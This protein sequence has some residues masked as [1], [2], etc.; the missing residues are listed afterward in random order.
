MLIQPRPFGGI[1]E[2]DMTKQR[3]ELRKQR[4]TH[5]PDDMYAWADNKPWWLI[6]L[7]VLGFVATG[8]GLTVCLYYATLILFLL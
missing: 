4:N 3:E 7:Q 8:V 5:D 2:N 6:P 1:K